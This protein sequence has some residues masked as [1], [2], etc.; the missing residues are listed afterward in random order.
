[1]PQGDVPPRTPPSRSPHPP[2]APT[3]TGAA[4]SR[5]RSSALRPG[6]PHCPR[7]LRTTPHGQRAD[8]LLHLFAT[9]FFALPGAALAW[10]TCQH[11]TRLLAAA[12]LLFVLAQALLHALCVGQPAQRATPHPL[13]LALAGHLPWLLLASVLLPLAAHQRTL[14]AAVLAALGLLAAVLMPVSAWRAVPR[15]LPTR[16]G[17]QA[18]AAGLLLCVVIA[19]CAPLPLAVV[20]WQAAALLALAASLALQLRPLQT[21]RTLLRHVL[22]VLG[23]LLQFIA[24]ALLV[25]PSVAATGG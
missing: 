16:R 21:G 11:G 17:L 3:L 9:L 1:M 13:L 23:S 20:A 22:V 6:L 4:W 7:W 12:V 14:A 19:L 15:R 25:A 8:V 18:A 10:A 24:I 2:G 5:R